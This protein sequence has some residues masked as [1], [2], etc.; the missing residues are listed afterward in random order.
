VQDIRIILCHKLRPTKSAMIVIVSGGWLVAAVN[1]RNPH[2][3]VLLSCE[4]PI[5]VFGHGGQ[6]I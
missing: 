3:I 4:T 6:E 1:E 2:E 5:F